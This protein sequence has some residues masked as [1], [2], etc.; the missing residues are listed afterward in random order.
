MLN[1]DLVGGPERGPYIFGPF[2]SRAINRQGRVYRMSDGSCMEFGRW[3]RS[4]MIDAYAQ[5]YTDMFPVFVER[6]NYLAEKY[7]EEYVSWKAVK[8]LG[9]L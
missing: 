4:K 2:S 1:N 3:L 8:R 9:L 7:P 6:M 5:K